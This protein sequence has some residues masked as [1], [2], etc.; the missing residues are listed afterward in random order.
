[1]TGWQTAGAIYLALGA[2]FAAT[3]MVEVETEEQRPEQGTARWW[4]L[5]VVSA[6]VVAIA[7]GPVVV[8]ALWD[9]EG[10]A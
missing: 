7:W 6:L 4:F 2:V 9:R 1:M 5:C 3:V 10:D 8:W